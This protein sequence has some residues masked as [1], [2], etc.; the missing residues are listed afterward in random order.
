MWEIILGSLP[1]SPLERLISVTVRLGATCPS[2]FYSTIVVV[3][4]GTTA[5]ID[6]SLFTSSKE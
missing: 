4:G 6:L 2:V 1:Q 3:R 5:V